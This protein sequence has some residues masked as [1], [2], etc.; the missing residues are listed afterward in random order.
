M[1]EEAKPQ[2]DGQKDSLVS[3]L[4]K[5]KVIETSLTTFNGK[6]DN[7]QPTRSERW[8]RS[9]A[10]A[11]LILVVWIGG[12]WLLVATQNI[13]GTISGKDWETVVLRSVV[14][15]SAFASLT[16]VSIAAMRRDW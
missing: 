14:L 3:V 6:L 9:F 15:V 10:P 2:A 13:W 11:I 8:W 5:L 16:A 4:D 7:Y 1:S 12:V